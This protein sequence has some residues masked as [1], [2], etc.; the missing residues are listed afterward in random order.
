MAKLNED[1]TVPLYAQLMTEIV[2]NITDGTYPVGSKIPSEEKLIARYG[3]SRITVRRAV[4]ELV[5]EG[6][7]EKHQGK[8]TFVL[9][10]KVKAKFTQDSTVQSFTQACADNGV[11]AG[12]RL[13]SCE[14]VSGMEEE[15]G[16]FGFGTEG[17][18]LRIERVRTADG[19]PIMVEENYFPADRYGFLSHVNLE[20][21]SIF[22]I[23]AE[24]LH[25]EP[26]LEEP[27]QLDIETAS[28]RHAKLLDAAYGEPM[29][30]YVGRYYDELNRAMCLG[31]QHI[32]GSRY[33]FKI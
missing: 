19:I 26:H 2:D 1:S 8:G 15:Q 4:Q 20:D 25:Q 32:V 17:T 31:K 18:L 33:S 24:R 10:R 30:Y 11:Q 21:T 12:A 23:I 22:E 3:V 16:F 9:Q 13:I 28:A 29:F 14:R 27:C 7:L 6:V 5:A